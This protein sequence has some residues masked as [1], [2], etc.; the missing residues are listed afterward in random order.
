M[1][2]VKADVNTWKGGV[3]S[4][5]EHGVTWAETRALPSWSLLFGYITSTSF[6]ARAEA[7]PAPRPPTTEPSVG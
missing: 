3:V 5:T 7:S 2:R 4:S 1:Q 6:T